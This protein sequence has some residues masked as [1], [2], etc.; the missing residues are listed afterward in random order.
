M[1]RQGGTIVV[2]KPNIPSF[3]DCPYC[4]GTKEKTV[5]SK[6]KICSICHTVFNIRSSFNWPHKK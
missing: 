4:V 5:N 3:L 2:L 6:T 1:S